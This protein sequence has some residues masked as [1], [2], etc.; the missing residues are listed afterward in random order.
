MRYIITEKQF[1]LL[2]ESEL[3]GNN[4]IKRRFDPDHLKMYIFD[5]I[6]EEES[7]CEYS[8]DDYVKEII[9]RAVVRAITIDEEMFVSMSHGDTTLEDNLFDLCYRLFKDDIIKDYNN[10]CS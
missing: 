2:K 5:E 7:V 4:W 6:E 9:M 1:N 3:Y 10:N 8:V